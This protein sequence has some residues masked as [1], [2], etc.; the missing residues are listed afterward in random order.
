MA[1]L[2]GH[3]DVM[4]ELIRGK[5]NPS[6][7]NTDPPGYI[8][9]IPL[10][11]AAEYG[12][13]DM[14]RELVQEFGVEGCDATNDG[15]EALRAATIKQHLDVMAILTMAGV[16]DTAGLALRA[17]AANGREESVKFLLRQRCKESN[18][19]S[20]DDVYINARPNGYTP[21]A[22][23]IHS[24]F[25]QA[26]RIV[27]LLIDAGADTTSAVGITNSQGELE[28]NDTPLAVTTSCLREKILAEGKLATE[29]HL[30]RL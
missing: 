1:A 5:A 25:S 29:E 14:V 28:F 21:L 27:R 30:H 16:V 22:A 7:T 17:A 26:P 6:L 3:M 18:S 11:L 19:S 20:V 24:C 4:R 13:S 12:H 2:K 15:R 10:D 23:S 8:P 9:T